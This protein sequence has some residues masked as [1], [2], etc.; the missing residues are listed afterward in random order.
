[1]PNTWAMFGR[2]FVMEWNGKISGIEKKIFSPHLGE[3]R[4]ESTLSLFER[5]MEIDGTENY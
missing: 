2:D 1:M 4:M 3:K 5:P